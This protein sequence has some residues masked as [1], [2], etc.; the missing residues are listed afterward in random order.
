MISLRGE[1]IRAYL[2]PDANCLLAV[3]EHCLRS[4]DYVNLI[5]I[6]KQPQLQYLDLEA[7]R[8]H[9]AAGAGI[10]SWASTAGGVEEADIVLAGAGRRAD[11]GDRRGRRPAARARARPGRAD[12]QRRRPDGARAAARPPARPGPGALPGAVRRRPRGRHGLPRLRARRRTSSCTAAR[13]RRASTCTGSGS[14]GRPRRRSTCSSSTTSAA[15]TC[16]CRRSRATP[17]RPPGCDELERHCRAQLERHHAYVREHF[18]D[19]PEVRDW[20]RAP[21]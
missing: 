17:R 3:A 20:V 8:T 16:A 5:V 4:R 9:C 11:P 13:T 21:A 10:W 14:R 7:A 12:R 6:D 15:T 1:V 2:P 19:M 18:E